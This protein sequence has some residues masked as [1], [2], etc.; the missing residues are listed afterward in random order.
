MFIRNIHVS[1]CFINFCLENGLEKKEYLKTFLSNTPNSVDQIQIQIHGLKFDQIQIC[2]CIC[3][4]KYKYVFDP[5][6][7]RCRSARWWL[8]PRLT[9]E[10]HNQTGIC[11][12]N[13]RNYS[14]RNKIYVLTS[15]LK[16]IYLQ[17][18]E[19]ARIH[20]TVNTMCHSCCHHC[21]FTSW[22]TQLGA[23]V[24]FGVITLI[25]KFGDQM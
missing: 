18:A 17:L 14:H 19:F 9:F 23:A 21:E 13:T 10:Y 11:F 2:I 15:L 6:P 16:Q 4:C 20:C 12:T 8:S 7:A 24:N 1:L 25:T 5:S 3:I 22:R